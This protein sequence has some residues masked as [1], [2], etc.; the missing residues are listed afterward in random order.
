MKCK[1][2]STIKNHAA[3]FLIATSC[4]AIILCGIGVAWFGWDKI[5]PKKESDVSVIATVADFALILGGLVALVVGLWRAWVAGVQASTAQLQ[6]ETAQ[7]TLLNERFQRAAD[8]LGSSVLAVRIG[9]VYA[10][11][12]LAIQHPA[13][14]HVQAMELLCAFV[15][16]AGQSGATSGISNPEDNDNALPLGDD[17]QAAARALAGRNQVGR[18]LE[19]KGQFELDLRGAYL[20][21][22]KLQNA[23]FAGAI[24]SE[25]NLSRVDLSHADLSD[26]YL[27]R[28]T[29]NSADLTDAAC[30]G[31]QMPGAKMRGTYAE[32]TIFCDVDLQ[33]V[34]FHAANLNGAIFSNANVMHASFIRT[35]VSGADF[36]TRGEKNN[37]SM[38]VPP[39][40]Y[41]GPTKSQLDLVIWDSAHPPRFS[42]GMADNA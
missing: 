9:G 13:D 28:T 30:T 8:M 19:P 18:D 16:S 3:F 4:L 41:T 11:Q 6:T 20:V 17:V 15:R 42:T 5:H 12:R 21:G 23:E 32:R 31:A 26:A 40:L 7:K 22:A 39:V 33:E 2:K 27:H 24:L 25:A 36:R 10:L 37:P 34:D 14:Y 38:P 1:I 29:L 35:E